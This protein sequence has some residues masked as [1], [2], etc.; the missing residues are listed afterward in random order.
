MFLDLLAQVVQA[1]T[2]LVAR[3]S[4]ANVDRAVFE[5]LLPRGDANWDPDQICVR[6]LLTRAQVAVVEEHV[7]AGCG[8]NLGRLSGDLLG[9]EQLDDVDVVRSDP[10]RPADPLLVEAL[11][12]ERGHH[13]RRPDALAAHDERL[14]LTVL[15][16]ERGAERLGVA[17]VELED[18]AHLDGRLELQS[19]AAHGARVAP[20][21]LA[22]VREAWL[23]VATCLDAAQVPAVA[24]RSGHE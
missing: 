8:E 22:Q 23:E 16:E 7:L 6:E 19:S 17:R 9:P 5:A 3:R 10:G 15:V 1:H 14:L 4:V 12:D 20:G 24:V 21:R 2:P 18:V 13:A 11:L